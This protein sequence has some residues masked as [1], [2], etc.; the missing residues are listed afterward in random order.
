MDLDE[1]SLTNSICSA[2]FHSKRPEQGAPA[3]N[4][5]VVTSRP[6]KESRREA[7]PQ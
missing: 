2:R 1:C 7:K 3:M 4:G 6:L 5:V